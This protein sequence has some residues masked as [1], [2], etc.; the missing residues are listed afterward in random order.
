MIT[1]MTDQA[2]P[3]PWVAEPVS[4][5]VKSDPEMQMP[6]GVDFWIAGG[7]TDE[8]IALTVGPI[9]IGSQAANACVLAAAPD[10]LA[11]CRRMLDCHQA[12]MDAAQSSAAA[13]VQRPCLCGA[14]DEARAAV[15]K[16]EGRS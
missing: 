3:G 2:T 8:V 9:G 6:D 16:A 4:L 15:A 12:G 13:F 5:A 10:L 14:C 1:V 7:P 11:A